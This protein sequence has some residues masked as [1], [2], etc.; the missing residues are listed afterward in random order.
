MVGVIEVETRVVRVGR[1]ATAVEALQAQVDAL[2]VSLIPH[3]SVTKL[4]TAESKQ[5]VHS[6][7]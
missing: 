3:Q 6:S 5:R 7:L 1:A 4:L 2:G